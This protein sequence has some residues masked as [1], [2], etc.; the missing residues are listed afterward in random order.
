[1][2]TGEVDVQVLQRP[3]LELVESGVRWSDICRA[4]G[5]VRD[6]RPEVERLKRRL[7]LYWQRGSGRK[8]TVTSGMRY[9]TAIA[10]ARAIEV[11]PVELGL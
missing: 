1:M 8:R 5:W 10:I 9:E 6:G 7:G 4:L 11:D 3:V 2:N